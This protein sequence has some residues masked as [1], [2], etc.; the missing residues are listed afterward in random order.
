MNKKIKRMLLSILFI[1]AC[2]R[3]FSQPVDLTGTWRGG[4]GQDDK[5]W[6]FDMT[7]NLQ[8]DKNTISG[9]AK[10][11]ANDGQGAY[12]VQSI[13]GEVYGNS[14]YLNDVSVKEENNLGGNWYWCKK[15]Y[16]GKITVSGDNIILSGD[17]KNEGKKIFHNK[18]LLE[19]TGV[20]CYPGNFRVSKAYEKKILLPDATPKKDSIVLS[21]AVHPKK[22]SV[23]MNRKITQV[24]TIDI[25]TDSLKLTFFDN[26]EIDNDTIS[27][28]YNKR[29]LLSHQRLTDKPLEIAIPVKPNTTNELLMFAENEGAIPPNT[30]LLIFEDN[31]KRNEI[32]IDSDTKKSGAVLFRR[33]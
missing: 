11:I 18:Q 25:S 1:T 6:V 14:I 28:Y 12:I 23:F 2:N 7:L 13:E 31:G 5:T 19:N 16:F 17:W 9:T 27:V 33:K 10:Y 3:L 22:D 20:Y 21:A 4:L 30:A 15:I 24:K 26:G 29:L 8:Q 32:R